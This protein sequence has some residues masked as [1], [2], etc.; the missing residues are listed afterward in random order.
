LKV[1]NGRY[2]AS[3]NYLFQTP[4][5]SSLSI[6]PSSPIFPIISKSPRIAHKT[7][8]LSSKMTACLLADSRVDGRGCVCVPPCRRGQSSTRPSR[9]LLSTSPVLRS[10]PAST[11]DLETQKSPLQDRPGT[12]IHTAGTQTML[13]CDTGGREAKL[14]F[15]RH[16]VDSVPRQFSGPSVGTAFP[17]MR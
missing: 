16:G 14:P 11:H 3:Q 10:K 15:Y 5:I 8:N 6:P 17:Q 12:R 1:G 13:S 9:F 2:R 4:T 7:A